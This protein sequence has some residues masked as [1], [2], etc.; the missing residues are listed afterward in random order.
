MLAGKAGGRAGSEHGVASGA[1]VF[2]SGAVKCLSA[3]GSPVIMVRRGMVTTDIEGMALAV[4][5]LTGSGGRTSHDVVARQL[6]KICLVACPI[7][8]SIWSDVS[9]GSAR[10]C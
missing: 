5:I 6:G 1:V 7:C 10:R 3:A 9:A 4:G 2:D 8:K